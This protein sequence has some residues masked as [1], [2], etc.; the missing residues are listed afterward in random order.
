MNLNKIVEFLNN[1]ARHYYNGNPIISDEQ[2]DKL[3]ESVDY[4]NIGAKQHDNVEKH[5][6]P[7][8]SLQKFY[9]DENKPS[10]LEGQR[11]VTST[12]K[13]DGAAVSHLFIDGVYVRSLTR[14]DGAEG[15]NVTP[16]F[17][18]T[19]LIPKTIP[20]MGMVQINGEIA[21]PKTVENS[22][23]YA[24]GA[25]NLKDAEEFKTRAVEFIAYGIVPYQNDTFDADMKTLQKWG[26]NTVADKNLE[27]IY[28]SDGIVFRVNSNAEY[29]RLG[30]TANH[31]KGA[32]AK[33]ERSEAVETKLVGVEWN[34]GKT[35]KVVPTALLEPV[36]IGDATVS[37]A[38][39]NNPGFIAALGLCIDDIVL[40]RRSG[41]I[42]PQI[43]GKVEG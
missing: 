19:N 32:Y 21:A 35:G 9:A 25:L 22:R 28:P 15:T 7:L 13:L 12:I 6:Y 16:K 17:L 33:K 26:F 5:V 4:H 20:V 30:F 38:T 10:P 18:A 36:K 1:A 11:D 14:G 23:N 40:V 37:R 2:F 3:A 31:P 24:A 29:D 27:L 34:V 8:W 39:L 42:I 43:I 41:E